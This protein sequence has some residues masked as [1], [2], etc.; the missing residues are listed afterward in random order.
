MLLNLI[1][2]ACGSQNLGGPQI[3]LIQSSVLV[4]AII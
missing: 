3:N 4:N 1:L 2:Q